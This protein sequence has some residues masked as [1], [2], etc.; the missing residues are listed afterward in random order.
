MVELLL[1]AGADVGSR[2][3]GGG[4]DLCRTALSVAIDHMDAKMAHLLF[5]HGV[6]PCDSLALLHAVVQWASY[7]NPEPLDL[8]LSESEKRY[9][10]GEKRY[11]PTPFQLAILYSNF[12]LME[13]LW[14]KTSFNLFCHYNDWTFLADW[15]VNLGLF[16]ATTLL[17]SAILMEGERVEEV[18]WLLEKG[19]KADGIVTKSPKLTALGLAAKSKSKNMVELLLSYGGNVDCPATFEVDRTALQQAAESGSFEITK[20]LLD[21]GADVNAVPARTGGGTALQFAA[22]TGLLRIVLLLLQAGADINAPP[23]KVNGKTALEGAAEWGRLDT[24]SLLLQAGAKT[25]GDYHRYFRSA[26][27]LAEGNGHSAVADVL[28][29]HGSPVTVPPNEVDVLDL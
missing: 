25:D 15:Y 26:I 27:R 11:G 23:A 9:P 24:V 13:R 22:Q 7:G 5:K 14:V 29:S 21:R 8:L 16:E 6:D 20:L 10:H 19:V 2:P 3:C 1:D 12:E 17:A 18:R 28:K 4:E